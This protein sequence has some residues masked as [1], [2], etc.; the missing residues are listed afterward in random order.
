MRV[1][2]LRFDTQDYYGSSRTITLH[3][4]CADWTTNSYYDSSGSDCLISDSRFRAH[5]GLDT[6]TV[7]VVKDG[8]S[9]RVDVLKTLTSFVT[10]L[11]SHVGSSDIRSLTSS[12]TY[13]PGSGRA[14]PTTVGATLDGSFGG[15]RYREF[16]LSLG[17]GQHVN[18]TPDSST[19]VYVLYSSSLSDDTC[20]GGTYGCSITA[21]EATTAD[22]YL[23]AGN[24]TTSDCYG[25]L[26][27]TCWWVPPDA[28]YHVSIQS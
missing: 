17:A 11:A 19:G 5:L 7:Y 9:Y 3:S 6:P 24:S 8:S 13:L 1:N 18:F 16:S 14:T 27:N 23:E 26:I 21:S 28:K 2:S 12:Y 15:R 10:Q 22:I 4:Y 25:G 20:Y